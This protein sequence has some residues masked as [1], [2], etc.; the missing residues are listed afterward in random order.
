[1]NT[2]DQCVEYHWIAGVWRDAYREAG[3][4]P[5][6]TYPVGVPFFGVRAPWPLFRIDHVFYRGKLEVSRAWTGVLP[7]SDHRYV[8]A[9]LVRPCR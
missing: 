5:G 4:G 9:E 3:Q 7:G 1:M 2:T 6:L 8:M